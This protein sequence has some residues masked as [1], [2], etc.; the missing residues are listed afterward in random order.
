MTIREKIQSTENAIE[1]I[2]NSQEYAIGSNRVVYARLNELRQE[3]SRLMALVREEADLDLTELD[4][5]MKYKGSNRASVSFI[6]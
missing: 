3:M 4:L 1:K 6:G 5:N 2:K